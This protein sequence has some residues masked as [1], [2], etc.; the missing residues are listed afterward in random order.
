MGFSGYFIGIIGDSM[1]F[2][3]YIANTSSNK[4]VIVKYNNKTMITR[5]DM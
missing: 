3:T 4:N 2:G 5:V 1:G